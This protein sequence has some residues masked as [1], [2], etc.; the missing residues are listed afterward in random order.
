MFF[1]LSFEQGIHSYS[2]YIIINM[3]I[4]T[5]HMRLIMSNKDYQ[6]DLLSGNRELQE[7]DN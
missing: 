7:H 5:N 6:L 3:E 1:S 2:L 4:N